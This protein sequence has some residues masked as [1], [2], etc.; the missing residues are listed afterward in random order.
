V[1]LDRAVL[2]SSVESW[3]QLPWGAPDQVVLPAFH[4]HAENA[5]KKPGPAPGSEV[6]LSVCGLMASGSRTL[7]VS[8]WRTGGQSSLDLVREFVQELPHA[9]AAEAWQRSV[10]LTMESRVNF[11][12]EPRIKASPSDNP[13]R[14]VHPFLWSGY[15]LVDSGI[16]P[17]K[18]DPPAAAAI[19]LKK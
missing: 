17:Q 15:L 5:L 14:A 18:E 10:F 2:G 11:E 9:T 19:E 7:L 3:M 12:A 6:F 13:P 8:R 16:L 4:T 1:T